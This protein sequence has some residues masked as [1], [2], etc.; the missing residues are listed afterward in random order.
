MLGEACRQARDWQRKIRAGRR[1]GSASTSPAASSRTAASRARSSASLAATGLDPACL[2]LEITESALM[3]NLNTGAGV[4]QR[5]HA[6]SVGLHLDDFGTGYS[7]LAYLHSFPVDALKV[8][9]SFVNRMDGAPP[10]ARDRQGD[11]VAGAEPRHGGDRRGRRDA[12]Q[13]D[14]LRALGCRRGQGFLFSKPLPADEAERLLAGGLPP[15][16]MY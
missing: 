1:W 15:M 6:M 4:I 10:P 12:R 2:T 11:R 8:D 7:S 5:L 14:A 9:R 16:P 13:A 3:H